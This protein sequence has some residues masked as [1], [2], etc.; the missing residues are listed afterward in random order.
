MAEPA[1]ANF[2]FTVR[3]REL[4]HIGNEAFDR[5]EMEMSLPTD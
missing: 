2:G 4:V 1:F 3:M 5:C